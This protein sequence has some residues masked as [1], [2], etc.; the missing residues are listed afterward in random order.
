[1][2][3]IRLRPRAR[4]D[5]GSTVAGAALLVAGMGAGAALLVASAWA[6]LGASAPP[7]PVL[8]A[9]L[10]VAVLG[11]CLAA[12]GR[13]EGGG[14]GEF[15]YVGLILALGLLVPFTAY[16][17]KAAVD[18][19]LAG[20][21][22]WGLWWQVGQLWRG[23]APLP[24]P[25]PR[26]DGQNGGEVLAPVRRDRP[27]P[28]IAEQVQGTVGGVFV[29]LG[30]LAVVAAGLGGAGGRAPALLAGIGMVAAVGCGLLL[31]AQGMRRWL[32]RRAA[33]DGAVVAMDFASR[34]AAFG[35][36]AVAACVAAAA[37][38]PAYPSLA[39]VRRADVGAV[40]ALL[41]HAA[42]RVGGSAMGGA[43]LAPGP[44]GPT[45]GPAG[46]GGA[47]LALGAYVVVGLV[48]LI[49]VYALVRLGI[50]WLRHGRGGGGRLA[51]WEVLSDLWEALRQA[52]AALVSV[53]W[54]WAPWWS[55]GRAAMRGGASGPQA[56]GLA[57]ARA[58][59]EP[60]FLAWWADPRRRVRLA[61]RRVLTQARAHG[62]VRPLSASPR[63]FEPEL[64]RRALGS[65]PAVAELTQ[66]YEYARYSAHPIPPA[67]AERAAGA[68]GE[69]G[70][71]LEANRQRRPD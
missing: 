37:V 15:A 58:V 47:A 11:R 59:A 34:S 45:Q 40:V 62:L 56:R 17:T 3:V 12:W 30:A 49:V 7:Y 44:A 52:L 27:Q 57:G 41:P 54:Q 67:E 43:H 65:E 60:G 1:M 55:G 8:A 9:A 42:A 16:R 19:G 18:L 53:L 63:R 39:G 4:R 70:R 26:A 10:L 24:P 13:P 33:V 32:A 28:S 5:A 20:L 51:L 48:A 31:L 29:A 38:L 50:E 2:G 66:L 61:Y 6:R 25:V 14:D 23:L 36:V 64:A 22:V 35:F 21:C 69:V 71:G 68:A 46:F